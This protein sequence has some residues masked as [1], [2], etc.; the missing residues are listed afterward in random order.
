MTKIENNILLFS[1]T[2]CWAASYIF[3]KSLPPDLSSFAYLTFTT[4]I[5][6]LILLVVFFNQLRKI[7]IKLV[8][9]AAFLSIL[10]TTNLI[11]E[12]NGI[13][14]LSASNASFLAAL[15]IIFVPL[16]ML[17]LKEKPTINNVLGAA[18]IV[19]G[20]CFANNFSIQGLFNRGA[21]YMLFGCL[22]SAIYI[23]SACRFAKEEN[24]LLIGI[25]QMC[26]TAIISFTLW[27]FEDSRT[28]L[29]INYTRELLSSI[30]VLAFFSKAYA[31]IILMFSQ[32]YASPISVTVI[33]STEPVV[34]L[35]LAVMIPVA[36]GEAEKLS[37]FSIFGAMMIAIGAVVAGTAF[38]RRKKNEEKE[39]PC[40]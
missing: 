32:K 29:S 40:N 35:L 9:K 39:V 18:I 24:P 21:M 1:I 19:L 20:L 36:F 37:V 30:F 23:I 5:A 11:L 38:L 13:S 31:Y 4:G 26:F 2:L 8:K 7:T 22:S 12:K 14:L 34:T 6:S 10:L 16:L 15:T 27:F 28:F 25:T 3:I 17:F 33:G